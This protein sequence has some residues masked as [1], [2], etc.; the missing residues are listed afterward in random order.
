MSALRQLNPDPLTAVRARMAA[1][2][3]RPDDVEALFEHLEALAK[4]AAAWK[5]RAEEAECFTKVLP[6]VELDE[7][8]FDFKACVTHDRTY[9]PDG[10][11]DYAGKSVV[12]YLEDAVTAQ[13]FRAITAEDK[14]EAAMA[15]EETPTET[16][17]R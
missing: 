4:L 10:A 11:C 9:A 6:C 8:P 3:Y 5:V 17:P 7:P 13:R 2:D 16:S 12:T 14:A 1:G 15:E